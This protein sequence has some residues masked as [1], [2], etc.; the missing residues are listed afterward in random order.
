MMQIPFHADQADK[1]KTEA[2]TARVM[3]NMKQLAGKHEERM[4]E[5]AGGVSK[6]ISK[7]ITRQRKCMTR[8]MCEEVKDIEVRP[9]FLFHKIHNLNS[10]TDICCLCDLEHVVFSTKRWQSSGMHSQGVQER[11]GKV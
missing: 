1:K 10:I 7:S 3:N 2:L 9:R 6:E 8:N 5:I 4:R 11:E